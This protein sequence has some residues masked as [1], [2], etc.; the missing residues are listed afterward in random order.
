MELPMSAPLHARVAERAGVSRP[1]VYKYVGDQDA[2]LRAVIEREGQRYI[3]AVIPELSRPLALREHFAH[4][5]AFSVM[6][7]R[8]SP[9]LQSVMDRDG[10]QFL[11]WLSRESGTFIRDGITPL[12]PLLHEQMPSTRSLPVPL[13]EVLEWGVRITF[14]LVFMP[15]GLRPLNTKQEVETYV[16]QFLLAFVPNAAPATTRPMAIARDTQGQ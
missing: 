16:G 13:E 4:L 12:V 5:T 7:F 11:H 1:T 9:L 14:A 2:L 3:A 6:F 15:S 10:A 8:A